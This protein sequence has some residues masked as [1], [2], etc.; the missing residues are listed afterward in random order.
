M[1]EYLKKLKGILKAL[2]L[3]VQ[4]SSNLSEGLRSLPDLKGNG[5][6]N[7]SRNGWPALEM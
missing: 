1:K 4:E 7:G 2:N 3:Y 5:F 6:K